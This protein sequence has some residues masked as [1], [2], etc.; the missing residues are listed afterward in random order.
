M[1]ALSLY[2][3]SAAST[4]LTTADQLYST[5]GT[6]STTNK[7]TSLGTATGYGELYS[8]SNNGA[9]AALSAIGTADGH[10][11]LLES[12]L[13]NLSGNQIN[14]ATWSGSLTLTAMQSGT[15]AGTFTADIHFRAFKRSSGGTYTQLV[16]MTALAQS[17]TATATTF[18]LSGTGIYTTFSAG[19]ALYLDCWLDVSSNANPSTQ[20]CRITHISTDTSGQT[21]DTK[22]SVTTPG[23][24]TISANTPYGITMSLSK[25]NP[26]ALTS[27]TMTDL[28]GW[29]AGS[30]LRYQLRW[31]SLELVQGTYD[32]TILAQLDAAVALCNANN[33]NICLPLSPAPNWYRSVDPSTG[34][35]NWP[36]T[37]AGFL[38]HPA[39]VANYASFIAN[40]YNGASGFGTVQ[41]I[42]IANEEYDLQ[43]PR[44][45][46]GQWMVAAAN[47]E[48]AAIKAVYPGCLVGMGAIR[49]VTN[50]QQSHVINWYTGA[51]TFNG[52]LSSA[53]RNDP[54]VWFDVH[55]YRGS[56]TTP[57]PNTGYTVAQHI[58]DI[59]SMLTQFGATGQI[60]CG[61][62]GYDFYDDAGGPS[63]TLGTAVTA[64]VPVT[65]IQ[66]ATAFGKTIPDACPITVDYKNAT[67][68]KQEEIY[69]Y[70]S[71][72]SSATLLQVTTN[73]LGSVSTQVAW[74]PAF[75]HAGGVTTYAALDQTIYA[76]AVAE[77][78]FYE[79]LD[80]LRTTGA[81][82]GFVY[83]AS[84]NSTVNTAVVPNSAGNSKSITQT[85]NSVYT[86]LLPYSDTTSGNGIKQYVAK[87]PT[88]VTAPPP[89]SSV[90]I[91]IVPAISR[92]SGTGVVSAR[93]DAT[94]ATTARRG[95]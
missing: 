8:Q 19:D 92:R 79:W 46:Q 48:Y 29:E 59:Q 93:R 41:A 76:Q 43:S 33:V 36:T 85:I 27:Q 94:G 34:L 16:D 26:P 5:S 22:A 3:S 67:L 50:N 52:G 58:K 15:P 90:N 73:P 7:N 70:G 95:D 61:E 21:G 68:A 31:D 63:T 80:A 1:T 47:A 14:A 39:S 77:N 88:W 30:W 78:Y 45:S 42:Q 54:T 69:A 55:I 49:G 6:P 66:V 60:W 89:S 83:T 35:D 65:S 81:A 37:T 18:S 24:V 20:A 53:I 12:S 82:K 86:Y 84:P 2:L 56:S 17:I 51:F 11:W 40:R 10:G 44:D 64:G 75:S 87:Y 91:A 13:L 38:P 32:P 62:F 72:P 57:D 71:Q 28:N 25:S 9:W 23:Y 4:T 74:T